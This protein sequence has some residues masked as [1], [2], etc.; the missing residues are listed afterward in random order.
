M[1]VPIS[2]GTIY[3]PF[4]GQFGSCPGPCAWKPDGAWRGR[5]KVGSLCLTR[6]GNRYNVWLVPGRQEHLC[7]INKLCRAIV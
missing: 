2:L 1:V 5:E 3:I 7:R 4:L 6:L